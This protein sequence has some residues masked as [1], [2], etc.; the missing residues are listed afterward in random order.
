MGEKYAYGKETYWTTSGDYFL[1][2]CA[3]FDKWYIAGEED[4][5]NNQRGGCTGYAR[6]PTKG[7]DLTHS[8]LISDWVEKGASEWISRPLAGVARFGK[9]S[10]PDMGNNDNPEAHS[11]D[12]AEGSKLGSEFV[13]GI[14]GDNGIPS[15][16][17]GA[18]TGSPPQTTKCPAKK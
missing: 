18:A 5:Q 9:F 6:A 2:W 16:E 12:T 10:V 1:Y 14:S 11:R 13:A 15:S 8:S 3:R 17:D 7:H 4:L